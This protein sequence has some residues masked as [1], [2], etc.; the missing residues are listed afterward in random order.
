VPTPSSDMPIE[1]QLF[2]V[3]VFDK[4]P[5]PMSEFSPWP[6]TPSAPPSGSGVGNNVFF[7]TD[8]AFEEDSEDDG[9]GDG[10]PGTTTVLI[11]VT[12]KGHSV[13]AKVSGF[14]PFAFICVDDGLGNLMFPYERRKLFDK[15]RKATGGGNIRIELKRAYKAYGF[16]PDHKSP[17]KRLVF[18]YAKVY[19]DSIKSM[20]YCFSKYGKQRHGAESEEDSARGAE[21]K[22]CDLRSLCFGGWVR[23]NSF[24]SV[25]NGD[26]HSYCD[27]E[28]RCDMMN[29]DPIPDMQKISPFRIVSFDIEQ[30]TPKMYKG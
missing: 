2:D 19:F 25:I 3:K 16:Y 26:H 24:T 18:N 1:F 12:E 7:S 13:C 23:I 11:G 15:V 14:E 9:D 8:F 10:E 30:Y 29:I 4:M 17:G 20:R 6:H 5:S 28:V 21:N 27:Y 22:F